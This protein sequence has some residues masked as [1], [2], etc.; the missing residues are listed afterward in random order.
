VSEKVGSGGCHGSNVRDIIEADLGVEG[1][2]TETPGLRDIRGSRGEKITIWN[3]DE[4]E[5]N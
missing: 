1:Y 5:P 2:L 3:I 4:D